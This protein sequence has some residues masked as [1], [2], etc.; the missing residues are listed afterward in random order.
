MNGVIA[1]IELYVFGLKGWS[2]AARSV[3]NAMRRE[4]TVPSPGTMGERRLG[5]TGVPDHGQLALSRSIFPPLDRRSSTGR[6]ASRRKRFCQPTPSQ[7][8]LLRRADLPPG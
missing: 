7:I 4:D 6:T 2:V 3:P 1:L 5:A 8:G